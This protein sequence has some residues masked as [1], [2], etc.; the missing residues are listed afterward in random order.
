[1]KKVSY[2]K[3][4]VQTNLGRD[5]GWFIEF[6]GQVIAELNP[7]EEKIFRNSYTLE[8]VKDEFKSVLSQNE[9]SW[10]YSMN[11][12]YRNKEFRENCYQAT[13]V[14][15]P[16]MHYIENTLILR[17]RVLNILVKPKGILDKTV[18]KI[19]CLVYG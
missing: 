11:L 7:F 5:C 3:K 12:C 8:N 10:W 2:Y 14:I 15:G 4:V 9:E 16:A 1:M 13:D 18:Y 19:I 6:K 17:Y